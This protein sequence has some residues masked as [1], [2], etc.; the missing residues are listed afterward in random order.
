[1]KDVVK[2]SKATMYEILYNWNF[3]A[4]PASIQYVANPTMNKFGKEKFGVITAV[5]NIGCI[6]GYDY[7]NSIKL[8]MAREGF[9]QVEIDSF[10]AGKLWNGKGQRHGSSAIHVENKIDKK[11]TGNKEITIIK[12]YVSYKWQQT[13]KSF[14]FDKDLN[15]LSKAD[16]VGCFPEKSES[17]LQNPIHPR[18][19]GLDN[20][21]K[22]KFKKVTYIIEG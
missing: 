2:I 8:Q 10:K 14:M 17:F 13:F 1:M 9:S 16:L 21:R 6:L 19:L 22:I 4:Q 15:L 5:K 20:V 12:K 7:E 18:E 11:A 3:G